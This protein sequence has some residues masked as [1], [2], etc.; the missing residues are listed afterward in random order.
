MKGEFLNSRS[1]VFC[2]VKEGEV[3]AIPE[4]RFLM[5]A[6]PKEIEKE[7]GK[8]DDKKRGRGRSRSRSRNRSRSRSRGRR[9]GQS[10]R[11]RNRNDRDVKYGRAGRSNDGKKIKGRGR[12]VSGK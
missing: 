8:S 3:P 5:R 7:Q 4:N 10:D 12:V 2:S 9:G 6:A 1:K 11:D